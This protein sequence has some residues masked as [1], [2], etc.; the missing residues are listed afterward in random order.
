MIGSLLFLGLYPLVR[1]LYS[2][3][4]SGNGCLGLHLWVCILNI[5]AQLLVYLVRGVQMILASRSTW[6]VMECGHVCDVMDSYFSGKRRVWA[7]L[8]HSYSVRR[9]L[10]SLCPLCSSIFRSTSSSRMFLPYKLR[11]VVT[12]QSTCECFGRRPVKLLI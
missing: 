8:S 10:V 3:R 2:G 4:S 7:V 6:A 12:S 9:W 11:R 5:Y 1:Y